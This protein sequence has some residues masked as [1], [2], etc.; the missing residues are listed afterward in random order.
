MW[1][2]RSVLGLCATAVLAAGGCSQNGS[3]R[4]SWIFQDEVTGPESP[5]T[6]CGR[7]YVDSIMA[8]GME[9]GGGPSRSWRSVRPVG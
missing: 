2:K 7:H 8:T 5:A 9:N 4:L 1:M 6:G 3:Y